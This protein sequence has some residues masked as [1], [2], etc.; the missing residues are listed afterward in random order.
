MM[1]KIS[2]KQ[3][4]DCGV[5]ERVGLV[6]RLLERLVFSR[7]KGLVQEEITKIDV[8]VMRQNDAHEDREIC[9]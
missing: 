7:R 8:R 6:V 2:V 3:W 1:R 5:K 9:A 4:R